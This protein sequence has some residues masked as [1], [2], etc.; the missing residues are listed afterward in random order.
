MLKSWL[1]YSVTFILPFH[2][3]CDRIIVQWQYP[4]R[5]RTGYIYVHVGTRELFSR[6]GTSHRPDVDDLMEIEDGVPAMVRKGTSKGV[7]TDT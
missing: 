6:I 4:E 1:H 3:G 5:L 2:D 7:M